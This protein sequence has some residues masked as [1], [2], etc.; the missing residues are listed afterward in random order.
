MENNICGNCGN[1]IEK[2]NRFCSKCGWD[3]ANAEPEGKARQTVFL[4]SLKIMNREEHGKIFKLEKP[5]I[6]IGRKDADIIINDSKISGK[7][8]SLEISGD[9]A[10]IKDLGSSNGTFHNGKRVMEAVLSDQ[11]K[12]RLGETILEYKKEEDVITGEEPENTVMENSLIDSGGNEAKTVNLLEIVSG[13]NRG[14]VIALNKKINILGRK[15]ADININDPK[16]SAKHAS[17]EINEE[18]VVLR[19]LESVNGVFLDG[20][21]IGECRISPGDMI[22]IGSTELL[23]KIASSGLDSE[24][25]DIDSTVSESALNTRTCSKCGNNAD[26]DDKFCAKCGHYLLDDFKDEKENISKDDEETRLKQEFPD[27]ILLVLSGEDRG[28]S[29]TITKSPTSVGRKNTDIIINDPMVSG[30]H[31]VLELIEGKALIR[32][33]ESANGVF[34]NDRPVTEAY[35]HPDDRIILGSSVIKYTKTLVSDEPTEDQ[36]YQPEELRE[37]KEDIIPAE[38]QDDK[39]DSEEIVSTRPIDS[40]QEKKP[41]RETV[42]RKKPKQEK[43]KKNRGCLILFL[44]IVLAMIFT[45]AVIYIKIKDTPYNPLRRLGSSVPDRAYAYI[46]YTDLTISD[47]F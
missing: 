8:A 3:A 7:H 43:G 23:Y 10:I 28:K 44:I 18:N 42:P 35:L 41:V 31:A 27:H 13:K 30:S 47:H 33:T 11:D 21:K 34:I 15:K 5:R 14:T 37:I 17:I 4:H 32:D 45:M 40:A 20:V 22:T 38:K 2:G 29:F 25:P 36:I 26:P 12:I 24:G 39:P 6:I 16:V 9:K 46:L 19:D 1:I